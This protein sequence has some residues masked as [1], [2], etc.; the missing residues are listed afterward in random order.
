MHKSLAA[1]FIAILILIVGSLSQATPV[2]A[3][4]EDTLF[5]ILVDRYAVSQS[6][7]GLGLTESFIGLVSTLREGQQVAFV[8]ADAPANV[9]GP[10]EAGGA[11]F[12]AVHKEF[13]SALASSEAA[14]AV[15]LVNSLGQTLNFL[16]DVEAS[17]GSTVY[18]VT[19]GE[20]REDVVSS[21]D[22]LTLIMNNFK[23]ARWPVVAVALPEVSPATSAFL[24]MISTEFGGDRYEL[25]AIG[26]FKEIADGILSDRARGGLVEMSSGTLSPSEV[27]T[28]SIDIAPGTGVATIVFFKDGQQ[29]SLRLSNP[30]GFEA[31]DGDRSV[32]SVFE[33]PYVVV[34][35]LLDPVPGEWNVEM[36]GAGQISAWQSTTNKLSVDL[37]SFDSVPY[38]L[39]AELVAFVS[40]GGELVRVDGVEVRAIITDTEGNITF[41]QLNDDG[42]LG[43]AIAGDGYYGTTISPLGVEGS[44]PVKLELYWPEYDYSISTMKTV[45]AQAFPSVQLSLLKTEDL[46]LAERNLVATALVHIEGQ[47]YAIST[48]QLS[49][50]IVSILAAPG[51]LEVLP[52]N[53]VN[54]GQAWGFDIYLTPTNEDLHTLIFNLN[55]QYAGR[56]YTYTSDSIVVS[57]LLPPPP[58]EPIVIV[59]PE[60]AP[61]VAPPVLVVNRGLPRELYAIPGIIGLAIL[62]WALYLLT[63]PKPFGYIY[64][65]QNVLLVDFA[66]LDRSAGAVFFSKNAVRGAELGVSELDGVSFKFTKDRVE[67]L[68]GRTEPTVRV[69][70][71]PLIEG[72]QTTI[73][74][75]SW[76]GTQGKLFSFFLSRPIMQPAPAVGDD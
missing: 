54:Q 19:G 18:T 21:S 53:L 61:I 65:D 52:Q 75:H 51:I 46:K 30:S 28:S 4:T 16:A 70:N 68:S 26:G 24:D 11:E 74:D 41:H 29:A 73:Y 1:S 56:E 27:I 12:K 63:R 13:M 20:L 58:P 36:R 48:D 25:S 44:Y 22:T 50:E 5:L 6:E 72:E 64:N 49:V 2:L 59:L 39:P 34:W 40:D 62:G 31:S 9:Y 15:N 67:L 57:S 35:R 38:D 23:D 60:P 33:T 3:E 17:A 69:D 45:S 14:V 66:D 47:P 71:Q 76:I 55:M 8:L 32:S 37:L 43:D 7:G 42:V 10:V